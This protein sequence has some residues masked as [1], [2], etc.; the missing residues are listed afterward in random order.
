MNS[1]QLSSRDRIVGRLEQITNSAKHGT[2]CL[3]HSVLNQGFPILHQATVRFC[4]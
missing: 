1:G 3:L 2:C 4:D